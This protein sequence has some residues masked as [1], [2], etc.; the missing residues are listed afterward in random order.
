MSPFESAVAA[1]SSNLCL[2]LSLSVPKLPLGGPFWVFL[3]PPTQSLH[4]L[5]SLALALRT[6]KVWEKK[7]PCPVS[8]REGLRCPLD[9]GISWVVRAQWAS[10]HPHHFLLSDEAGF[11]ASSMVPSEQA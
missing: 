7:N 4:P 9:S 11:E 1:T 5:L 10:L 6:A 3:L 2:E 8:S